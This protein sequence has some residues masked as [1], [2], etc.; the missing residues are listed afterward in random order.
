MRDVNKEFESLKNMLSQRVSPALSGPLLKAL[1][2]ALEDFRGSLTC[3][4]ARLEQEI[5]DLKNENALLR[6]LMGTHESDIVAKILSQGEEIR[7]LRT[8]LLETRKSLDESRS[9][10]DALSTEGEMNR[11]SLQKNIELREKEHDRFEKELVSLREQM[12][13]LEQKALEYGNGIAGG[14]NGAPQKAPPPVQPPA[15]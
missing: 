7:F 1:L 8:K 11:A 4:C 12:K 6:G 13:N 10:N 9:R 3:E 14:N 2:S 15:K 5:T